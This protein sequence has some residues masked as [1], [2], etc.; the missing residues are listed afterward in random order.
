MRTSFAECGTI[1]LKPVIRF[2]EAVLS[3]LPHI[4]LPDH[5]TERPLGHLLRL[6][7]RFSRRLQRRLVTPDMKKP[8]CPVWVRRSVF[9]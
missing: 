4:A 9:R 7:R 8:P 5:G 2:L 3:C 6:S 1:L